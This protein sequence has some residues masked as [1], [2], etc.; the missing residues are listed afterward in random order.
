MH[1]HHLPLSAAGDVVLVLE[2]RSAAPLRAETSR[3]FTSR[4]L[5][6][7]HLRDPRDDGGTLL[8]FVRD[9]DPAAVRYVRE[10]DAWAPRR[11]LIPLEW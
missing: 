9:D 7:P 1:D 10:P 5:L 4:L 3:Y 8:P 2:P 6:L 11:V